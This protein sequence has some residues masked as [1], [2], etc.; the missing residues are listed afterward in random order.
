[1]APPAE[2]GTPSWFQQQTIVKQIS[3]PSIESTADGNDG[4]SFT[5]G[6]ALPEMMGYLFA[7]NF[8][9]LGNNESGFF[10]KIGFESLAKSN[11]VLGYSYFTPMT[12]DGKPLLCST[13]SGAGCNT[14]QHAHMY[15]RGYPTA[16]SG[17]MFALVDDI[18]DINPA[19]MLQAMFSDATG[20]EPKCVSVSLPVGSAFDH[21]T[22]PFPS[23]APD[24]NLGYQPSLSAAQKTYTTCLS[25]CA[26]TE[27]TKAAALDNCN[28][29]CQRLWWVEPRCIP[30]PASTIPVSYQK[31]P[32]NA[33]QTFNIP[34]GATQKQLNAN[35]GTSPDAL[36]QK[37]NYQEPFVSDTDHHA[38]T[39]RRWHVHLGRTLLLL[40]L[41]VVVFVALVWLLIARRV[42]A[43]T[44]GV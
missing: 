23:D 2:F 17:N 32:S 10:G 44:G 3:C 41:L 39:R 21:C 42:R 6:T 20:A 7:Y 19:A 15:I 35:K 1:M 30:E 31:C 9:G 22:P 8:S 40:L 43:V 12:R 38:S 24:M 5:F 16:P 18:I 4:L 14:G 36:Q 29:D 33:K 37:Q 13:D 28:K 34:I 26:K 27:A 25:L 11:R